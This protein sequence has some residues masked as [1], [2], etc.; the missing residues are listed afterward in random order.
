MRAASSIP[1][2]IWGTMYLKPCQQQQQQQQQLQ[3]THSFLTLLLSGVCCCYGETQLVWTHWLV[4]CSCS[5]RLQ[6]QAIG[7]TYLH[8]G[9]IYPSALSLMV[10]EHWLCKPSQV[11]SLIL[12]VFLNQVRL[13]LVITNNPP[14][15]FT[16]FLNH[17]LRFGFVVKMYTSG[18][19]CF[20]LL[21]IILR[22]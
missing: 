1:S 5:L 20:P 12:P 22:Q 17:S 2:L 4:L 11:C 3:Q 16:F 7:Y 14:C 21:L 19:L 10:T 18:W 9:S 13:T 8:L 6:V 15:C